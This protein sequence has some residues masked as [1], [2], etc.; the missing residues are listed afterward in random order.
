MLAFFDLVLKIAYLA[1]DFGL[2][3][4]LTG[5][6]FDSLLKLRQQLSFKT[7]SI[8]T[9]WTVLVVGC[10][11]AYSHVGPRDVREIQKSGSMLASR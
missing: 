9:A 11:I 7:I 2:V 3:V 8:A 4:V 5:V 6:A 10:W 1:L